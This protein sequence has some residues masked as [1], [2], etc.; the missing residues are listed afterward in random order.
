MRVPDR[1]LA[2]RTIRQRRICQKLSSQLE[3]AFRKLRLCPRKLF[4]RI[5]FRRVNYSAGWRYERERGDGMVGIF[6][7]GAPHAT[8]VVRNH[9]SDRASMRARGIRSQPATVPLQQ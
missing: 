2:T 9:A 4:F 6:L 1:V 7:H 5:G 3:Q 8:G